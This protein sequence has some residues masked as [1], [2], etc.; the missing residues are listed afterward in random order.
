MQRLLSSVLGVTAGFSP[1]DRGIGFSG[2][3]KGVKF[4]VSGLGGL[5]VRLR[6][7]WGSEPR[8]SGIGA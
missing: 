1:P 7:T 6:P 8:A 3:W 5:K 2:L 4:R